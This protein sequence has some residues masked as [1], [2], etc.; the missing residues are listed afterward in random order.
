MVITKDFGIKLSPQDKSKDSPLPVK[1]GVSPTCL[2]LPEGDWSTVF[3][4]FLQKFS[5]LNKDECA[6]RFQRNE[7]VT[8]SGRILSIDSTYLSGEHIYFYREIEDEPEIPFEER[9]IYQNES[10]LVADKPHFLPVAPTGRYL[11]QSLLVRLRQKTGLDTLELC[12]RLDRETAGVVL[13][14]KKASLRADYHAL[15]SE[16]KISKIYHA[17]APTVEMQFPFCKKSRFEK[18]EPFFRMKEVEGEPNSETHIDVMQRRGNE[19]LYKL[20]PVTGKKHQLRV[21]MA[22]LNMAIKNDVFYP[23]LI[24]KDIEDYSSPLQ[25]LAKSIEFI[26]PIS[27]EKL[28]F[29]SHFSL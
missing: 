17:V 10:I 27:Q 9:I 13:L 19:T 1:N 22:S 3:E 12:H 16:R 20:S 11:R 28:F 2:W 7:V 21:H 26:D 18:G 15:F 8:A 14:T 25:L 23:D 6:R 24:E 5:H 29:E 4:F